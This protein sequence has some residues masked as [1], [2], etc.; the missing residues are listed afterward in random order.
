M[1][2]VETRTTGV[3]G[4]ASETA[5]V[6]PSG[7]TLRRQGQPYRIEPRRQAFETRAVA[8][9]ALFPARIIIRPNAAAN[10]TEP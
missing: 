9:E 10:P 4:I 7:S 2:S 1:Y 3:L 8:S 6:H 5:G